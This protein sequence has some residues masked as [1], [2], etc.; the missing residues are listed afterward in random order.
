MMAILNLVFGPDPIFEQKASKV[1]TFDNKL[2]QK[3]SDMTDTL[4]HQKALGMGANILG[5]LEQQLWIYKNQV[6]NNFIN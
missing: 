6:K 3:L 5:I 2:Q 4:Y 1:T